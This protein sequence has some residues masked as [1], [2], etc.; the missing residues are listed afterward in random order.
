[1]IEELVKALENMIAPFSDMDEV[2]LTIDCLDNLGARMGMDRANEIIAARAAL[3]TYQ[4]EKDK[5]VWVRRD[6]L[7]EAVAYLVG[8]GISPT[9]VWPILGRSCQDYWIAYLTE[10]D[11]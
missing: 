1:M 9:R 7:G 4:S 3:S 6:R 5:G 10:A 11:N 8:S 2:A